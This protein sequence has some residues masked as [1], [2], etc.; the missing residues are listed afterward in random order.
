MSVKQNAF[1]ILALIAESPRSH[2]ELM[3][4]TGQNDVVVT[5]TLRAAQFHGLIR[6]IGNRHSASGTGRPQILF[7]L[8]V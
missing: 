4:L 1:R 6:P 8:D 5:G 7:G 3:H 2:T